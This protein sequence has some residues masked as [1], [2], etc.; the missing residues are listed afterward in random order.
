[1]AALLIVSAASWNVARAL[2]NDRSIQGKILAWK[3]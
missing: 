2:A 3:F 1:L